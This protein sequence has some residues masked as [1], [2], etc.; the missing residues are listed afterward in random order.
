MASRSSE[1]NFTKNYTLLFLPSIYD[2]HTDGEGVQP[3]VDAC[4]Q[5][6]GEGRVKAIMMSTIK[7][8]NIISISH[9]AINPRTVSS[10]KCL[11]Q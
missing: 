8:I 2:V 10:C 11:F 6:E 7:N 1:V 3:K 9:T 5:G 4:G